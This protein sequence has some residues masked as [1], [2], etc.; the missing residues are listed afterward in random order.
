MLGSVTLDLDPVNR[1][2]STVGRLGPRQYCVGLRII[3]CGS[4]YFL[5]G[6][7]RRGPPARV[8]QGSLVE[9]LN[10]RTVCLQFRL[11]LT[12]GCRNLSKDPVSGSGLCPLSLSWKMSG[13]HS[14]GHET[15]AMPKSSSHRQTNA[16]SHEIIGNFMTKM[17][18][19]LEATL[20]NRR[21]ERAQNTSNDE[22]LERFL[23]F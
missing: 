7:V 8:A 3:L 9:K 4:G 11:V 15:E 14:P 12:A 2:R 20:T 21:G 10:V 23:R 16:A 6:W 5:V 19:L 18:E 22:A 17:T 13:P 1:G